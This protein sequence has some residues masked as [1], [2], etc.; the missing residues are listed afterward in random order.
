MVRAYVIFKRVPSVC[1]NKVDQLVKCLMECWCAMRS[2][3]VVARAHARGE[4]LRKVTF[5][6]DEDDDTDLCEYRRWDHELD[7]F[8]RL[9]LLISMQVNYVCFILRKLIA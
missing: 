2:L 8:Y 7:Y 9:S 1:K 6:D 4:V 3:Y 5:L